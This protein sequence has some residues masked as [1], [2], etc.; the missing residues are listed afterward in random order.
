MPPWRE[1][2]R[3]V[4]GGRTWTTIPPSLHH[5]STHPLIHSFPHSLIPS[6]RRPHPLGLPPVYSADAPRRVPPI[7]GPGH[8]RRCDDAFAAVLLRG[9]PRAERR[10][11][12]P[13]RSPREEL[14]RP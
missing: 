7:R 4:L 12:Y 5:S 11:H 8:F 14:D 2:S 10:D 9:M 3:A 1:R 13:D 6:Q